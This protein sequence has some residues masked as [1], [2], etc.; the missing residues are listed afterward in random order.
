V[1]EVDLDERLKWN[2]LGDFKAE[3]PRHRPVAVAEDSALSETATPLNT[4]T[5]R[6]KKA[7][8]KLLFDGKTTQ[9]WRGY[10]RDTMPPGWQVIDGVLTRVSGGEGGKGAGGGDDIVTVDQ[11][12]SFELSLEWQIAAGGNSGVLYHVTE[13]QLARRARDADSRQ[14]PVAHA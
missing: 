9:G 6:E 8:W 12:E 7:G 3:L 14:R 2:S 11:Y 4:L 5:D 1:A 13:H 10:N